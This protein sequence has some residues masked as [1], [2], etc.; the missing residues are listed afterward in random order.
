MNR[1]DGLAQKLDGVADT[2]RLDGLESDHERQ[3]A[4]LPARFTSC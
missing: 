1:V 4:E 2:V 3:S